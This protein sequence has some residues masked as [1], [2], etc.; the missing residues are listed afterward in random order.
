MRFP[1]LLLYHFGADYL[2]SALGQHLDMP[3][4]LPLQLMLQLQ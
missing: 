4:L 3:M 1:C 2:Q